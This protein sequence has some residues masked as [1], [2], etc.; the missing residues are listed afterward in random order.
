MN[1]ART[2]TVRTAWNRGEVFTL[3]GVIYGLRDGLLHDLGMKLTG[4]ADG[5]AEA[6]AAAVAG[7]K[8]REPHHP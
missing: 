3:H 2:T 5:A 1:V 7:L 8:P 6:Y 4:T